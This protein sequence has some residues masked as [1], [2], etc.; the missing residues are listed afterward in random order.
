[1]EM[2][3][4]F[5]IPPFSTLVSERLGSQLMAKG[6]VNQ[7]DLT[8]LDAKF[9]Y[10]LS[11]ADVVPIVNVLV[12][13]APRQHKCSVDIQLVV[14]S[15]SSRRKFESIRELRHSYADVSP[16]E[17]TSMIEGCVGD[18]INQISRVA[19]TPQ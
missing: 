12:S 19:N 9:E 10:N 3:D 18:I 7:L 5:T 13:L 14:G 1:M 6:G 16:E 11:V 17:Q 8:L 15:I 2:S 4:D